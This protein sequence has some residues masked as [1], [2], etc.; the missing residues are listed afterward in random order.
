MSHFNPLRAID[1]LNPAR[2]S[3]GL[4]NLFHGGDRARTGRKP[5]YIN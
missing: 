1:L 5:S 4:T 3:A 2:A